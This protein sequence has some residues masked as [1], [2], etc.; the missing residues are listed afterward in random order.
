MSYHGYV[1][2]LKHFLASRS[3]PKILEVGVDRGVT[4]LPL[5]TFLA[6]HCQTSYAYIGVDVNVQEAVKLTLAYMEPPVPQ[7]TFLFEENSLDFLPRAVDMQHKFDLVLL[8]GDHNYHTVSQELKSIELL[9]KQD[10]ILLID[11]YDGK[12]SNRDLW[13]KERPGYEENEKVTAPVETEK[14]G[15]KPAV[16]EWLLRHPEMKRYTLIPGEP[17]LVTQLDIQT[18][19]P[20]G[21]NA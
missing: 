21:G 15:V 19:Q 13:Y 10:G 1:P 12:W 16:D 17:L 8:D 14:H 9:L 18:Q 2:F 3:E 4:L 6:Q 11:D 20:Q 5:V 7:S